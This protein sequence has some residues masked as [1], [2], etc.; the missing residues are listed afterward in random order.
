MWQQAL[1]D[2]ER[3]IGMSGTVLHIAN[4][5]YTPTGPLVQ[6]GK[7]ANLYFASSSFPIIRFLDIGPPARL[8]QVQIRLFSP[9]NLLPS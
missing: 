4:Y 3:L 8:L 7:Y 5:D 1:H 6:A 9:S 2:I